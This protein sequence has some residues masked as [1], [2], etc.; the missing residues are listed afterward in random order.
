MTHVHL[1]RLLIDLEN[2]SPMDFFDD[3]FRQFY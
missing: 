3:L 2:L 1:F